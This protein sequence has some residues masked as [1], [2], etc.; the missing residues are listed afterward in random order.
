[1]AGPVPPSRTNSASTRP[2][3]GAATS[4]TIVEPFR[5][6]VP[7]ITAWVGAL[8]SALIASGAN[9][10]GAGGAGRAGGVGLALASAAAR[11]GSGSGRGSA[12]PRRAWPGSG[13]R[14]APRREASA[15]G[16]QY[17]S[18]RNGD[19]LSMQRGERAMSAEGSRGH[20]V[21]P[22][23][24][25]G[26][27]ESADTRCAPR[28]AKRRGAGRRAR[29]T[30]IGALRGRWRV[31]AGHNRPILITVACA[32]PL[33]FAD[34]AARPALTRRAARRP[35]RQPAPARTACRTRR[36][37]PH[38]RRGRA[39]ARDSTSRSMRPAAA[40]RDPRPRASAAARTGDA[41]AHCARAAG[42]RAPAAPQ[43][44]VDAR[45]RSRDPRSAR[46]LSPRAMP[47]TRSVAR[48]RGACRGVTPSGGGRPRDRDQ[49]G[50][51][52]LHGPV[53]ARQRAGGRRRAPRPAPLPSPSRGAPASPR[54]PLPR[55]GTTTPAPPL[56]PP[57]DPVP[58]SSPSSRSA[59]AGPGCL[60]AARLARLTC[61]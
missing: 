15:S 14:R 28:L 11:R 7:R 21:S 1:M 10:L 53:S 8:A 41:P 9:D 40:R 4:G 38:S 39:I 48:Q 27:E 61:V 30:T 33:R 3:A 5:S 18:P 25:A 55:G 23:H 6:S 52:G 17:S 51:G 32:G 60:S 44:V 29:R 20:S 59:R 22:C 31:R 54:F 19:R 42:K 13:A 50:P 26:W 12:Q 24:R 34:A 37:S 35:A 43:S 58:P 46:A 47:R 57:L 36:G 56:P 49:D 16:E 2:V 45:H